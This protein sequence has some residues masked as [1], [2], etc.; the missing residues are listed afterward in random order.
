MNTYQAT[1]LTQQHRTQLE[2]AARRHSV[3]RAARRA[4]TS[5]AAPAK[6]VAP[7]R[8]SLRRLGH[9]LRIAG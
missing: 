2:G 3:V 7:G 6:T 4:R 5:D 1:L 9:V 8:R